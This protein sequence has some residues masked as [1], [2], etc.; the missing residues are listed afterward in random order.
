VVQ[1]VL[2][3]KLMQRIHES[4]LSIRGVL[5]VKPI[6]VLQVVGALNRGGAESMI[7]NLYRNINR[8]KIHFDFVVHSSEKGAFD[9]EVSSLGGKI[10][11]CP[12]FNGVNILQYKKWWQDFLA[13]HSEYR[14]LHSHI[15]SCASLYL[16]I[17][18]SQGIRTIVHSH[19][20]SNGKGIRS[21][22]KRVLQYPLR[23]QADYLMSC[24]KK[25][26]E[27]LFGKKAAESNKYKFLPNAI[28][29]DKYAFNPAIRNQYRKLFDINDKVVF[30]HVGRFYES[31]NHGFL[32]EVFSEVQRNNPNTALFLVGD[33]PLRNEIENKINKLNLKGS[34]YLLG[35]RNDVHNVLQAIDVFLFPSIWEGFPV[36]V[37]EAQAAGLPC[38][39]SD[40]ITAEVA[41]TELIYRL[42]IDSINQWVDLALSGLE[43]KDVTERIKKAGFDVKESAKDLSEFYQHCCKS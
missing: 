24:S 5:K 40:R 19:N 12:R 1:D 22:A 36:A 31:K 30:G 43:R 7:M 25:A 42:P 26:G 27:W 11:K 15:R 14:I 8:D 41:L 4:Q 28:E 16:P 23:H 9:D 10:Y 21:L 35:V 29:V 33:G 39:I 2:W 20:T 3:E 32:L 38:I 6:Y 34:V 13:T 17:A 18:K 37:I